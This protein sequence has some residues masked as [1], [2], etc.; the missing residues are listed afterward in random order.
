M[1]MV[2]LT[3]GF[4]SFMVFLFDREIEVAMAGE[5]LFLLPVWLQISG[6]GPR[7]CWSRE[8]FVCDRCICVSLG[9]ELGEY[10]GYLRVFARKSLWY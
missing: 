8:S 10:V 2:E 4:H 9:C 3:L 5:C 7:N 6:T 1:A